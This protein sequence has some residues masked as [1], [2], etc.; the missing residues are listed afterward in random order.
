[1]KKSLLL[2]ASALF[3]LPLFALPQFASTAWAEEA[4]AHKTPSGW[5]DMENCA[6]CKNLVQDPGLLPHTTWENFAIE[7][8]MMNIF[9]VAPEYAASMATCTAAMEELG[10]KLH[11]GEVNPADVK[12][13]GH[14]MAYGGLM[15]AGVKMETVKG[16]AAEVTLMTSGDPAVVA[17]IHTMVERD[18]EEMALMMSGDPHQGHQH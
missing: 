12:M 16:K 10:A 6:F 2:I 1:M 5:F 15:A 8:G 17:K 13:C 18:N 14:C 7:N 9:T 4:M 11:S 3:A